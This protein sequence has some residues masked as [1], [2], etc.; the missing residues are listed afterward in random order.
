MPVSE[1]YTNGV[2][3]NVSLFDLLQ[4]G[5]IEIIE[6]ER[7]NSSPS[8]VLYRRVPED[9]IWIV[10]GIDIYAKKE[11]DAQWTNLFADIEGY[12]THSSEYPLSYLFKYS[13]SS[14][15]VRL[16]FPNGVT[17]EDLSKQ[18]PYIM[19]PEEQ[20]VF[21]LTTSGGNV[22]KLA[23]KIKIVRVDVKGLVYQVG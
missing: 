14:S 12:F 23:Y 11:A 9:E 5:R 1:I 22:L 18:Y 2:I 3:V 13:G 20:I 7:S 19:L 10:L 8:L 16:S 4:K 15:S 6:E 17:D 21:Y